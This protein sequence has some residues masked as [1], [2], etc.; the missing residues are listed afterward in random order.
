MIFLANVR[1]TAISVLAIPL[2]LAVAVLAMQALGFTINTMTLG[3]M[4]IAIG[5]LVD[6]AIIDVENV[7]R[8]LK[9]NRHLPPGQRHPALRVVYRASREIRGSIVSATLIIIVVFVPLFCSAA[10]KG[11]SSARSAWLTSWRWWP[12]WWSP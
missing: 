1:A 9:E 11:A 3:G 7:F 10:W 12:R 4:A 2:S 6:D 5:A 8:R